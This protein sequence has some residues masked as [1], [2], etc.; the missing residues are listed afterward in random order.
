VTSA[1]VTGAGAGLGRALAQGLADSGTHVLVA[2]IDADAAEVTARMLG[3]RAVQADIRDP[4]ECHRLVRLAVEAGGP[5]ILVNNAGGWTPGDK[6]YPDAPA[7][8]M[9]CI[10][11]GWIGLE[12]AHAQFAALAPEVRAK[13]VPLIPPADVVALALDLIATGRSGTVVEI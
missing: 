1:I 8:A 5:H 4:A 12:R 10:V 2:D 6:Q 9:M 3:G 7:D 13:T 11:P